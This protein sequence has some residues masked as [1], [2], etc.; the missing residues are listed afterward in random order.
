M[1]SGIEKVLINLRTTAVS[2]TYDVKGR[3]VYASS[4]DDKSIVR[5]IYY[6]EGRGLHRVTFDGLENQVVVNLTARPIGI[7]IDFVDQR[8]YWMELETGDLKSAL[9][10]GS[11]VKTVVSTNVKHNNREI[12][13]GDDYVFFTSYN[14]ILKIHKSLGQLPA[15]VYTGP[16]QIY[17]LIFYKE[18]R[19]EKLLFSTSTKMKEINLD[20]GIVKEL[21]NL[22]KTVYSITYD[23]KGRYMY[24]SRYV[25]GSIVRFHYPNDQEVYLETVV[26]TPRPYSIKFDSENR[27][28]YWTEY[29]SLRKIKRCITTIVNAPH[30]LGLTLDTH[31]RL[32]YY[33]E[34]NALH[35]VTFDGLENEVLVNQTERPIDIHIDFDD[36]RVYWMEY[37]TGDLKSALY[38]G[39]DVKTV[40]STSLTFNSRDIVIV[41]DYVYYT[42]SRNILKIHKSSGQMPTVVHTEPKQI[43]GLF[44]L[45]TR[46][47]PLG[48]IRIEESEE[49]YVI[50]YEK[51]SK[52]LL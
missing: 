44:V 3:Y 32:I 29:T 16:I 7:E 33:G 50:T 13:I 8:V 21:F 25:Y 48:N 2:I 43:F 24:A 17:G 10:N 38:N 15:V 35:R 28:L 14:K 52:L 41:N 5:W 39:S 51:A 37:E 18:G 6:S 49:T 46:R 11:D 27:H 23:V 34:G 36:K 22:S 45:Y 31:N 30:P 12:G 1:D 9:Y 4:Y 40:V 19:Q 42:S 20:T 26:N 47:V